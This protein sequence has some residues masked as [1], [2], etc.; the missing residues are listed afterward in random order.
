M[1]SSSEDDEASADEL[2][3]QT[4]LKSAH[5][6]NNVRY[7][8]VALHNAV[9]NFMNGLQRDIGLDGEC[10]E[11]A[12]IIHEVSSWW[13]TERWDRAHPY[14]D[15]DDE[16]NNTS[17]E[18]GDDE[19]GADAKDN[20]DDDEHFVDAEAPPSSP[21]SPTI[22]LGE[23]RDADDGE[24]DDP[25][26]SK[27]G[28][29]S[30]GDFLDKSD[31]VDA[32]RG[33]K[34]QRRVA[35]TMMSNCPSGNNVFLNSRDESSV[36]SGERA[37]LPLNS[38]ASV[39]IV[40]QDDEQGNKTTQAVVRCVVAAVNYDSAVPPP[41][42]AVKS[43]SAAPPPTAAHRASSSET[44]A[45][46]GG[47]A[48]P[49]RTGNA[50]VFTARC[51]PE[52]KGANMALGLDAP[53]NV[54]GT[55]AAFI[56]HG[57]DSSA[58]G[59]ATAAISMNTKAEIMFRRAMRKSTHVANDIDMPVALLLA[60]ALEECVLKSQRPTAPKPPRKNPINVRLVYGDE[61]F[62]S[63]TLKSDDYTVKFGSQLLGASNFMTKDAGSS[64]SNVT[65]EE[66][67]VADIASRR[68]TQSNEEYAKW[69]GTN[70]DA[71][72]VW[73]RK[74]YETEG[75]ALFNATLDT[76]RVL[77]NNVRNGWAPQILFE[78]KSK[79][80]ALLSSMRV[81]EVNSGDTGAAHFDSIFFA[82]KDASDIAKPDVTDEE[83]KRITHTIVTCILAPIVV[84]VRNEYDPSITTTPAYRSIY[85]RFGGDPDTLEKNLK[86]TQPL[87]SLALSSMEQLDG[88]TSTR[89]YGE[90]PYTDLQGPKPTQEAMS[91]L[92]LAKDGTLD[93]SA[94][95][96]H[97]SV[98][99]AAQ[100]LRHMTDGTAQ[101]QKDVDAAWTL[102]MNGRLVTHC[103]RKGNQGDQ[104]W[105]KRIECG[106]GA[107]HE[108]SCSYAV[109]TKIADHH[110]VE[111]V[112]STTTFPTTLLAKW[113]KDD[114]WEKAKAFLAEDRR[115]LFAK[116]KQEVKAL[117]NNGFHG[118]T[119]ATTRRSPSANPTPPR[120]SAT[121]K[122]ATTTDKVGTTAQAAQ[123]AMRTWALA[124]VQHNKAG[125]D[126][127]TSAIGGLLTKKGKALNADA[128]ET[129]TSEIKGMWDEF[130]AASGK[131]P[132]VVMVM[133]RTTRA[134]PTKQ[135]MAAFGR[136]MV[137][138]RNE[139]GSTPKSTTAK[140][141]IKYLVE[142]YGEGG[143]SEPAVNVKKNSG[144]EGEQPLP[145]TKNAGLDNLS[146]AT[147]AEPVHGDEGNARKGPGT[148]AKEVRKKNDEEENK[149]K[150]KENE[151]REAER[152]ANE[153]RNKKQDDAERTPSRKPSSG[154]SV[155]A[156]GSSSQENPMYADAVPV[157]ERL[158][159]KY[160]NN[161]ATDADEKVVEEF[162]E[163]VKG[164]HPGFKDAT[165][166]QRAVLN[167]FVEAINHRY[168]GFTIDD[169]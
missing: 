146:A 129:K 160:E 72:A 88:K 105:A 138:W 98:L 84:L 18:D 67:K 92:L 158:L 28:A 1:S 36:A 164:S 113:Q 32:E 121:K 22:T 33:A 124:S 57:L 49:T 85:A 26:E 104:L 39:A 141:Y 70:S 136:E 97:T 62:L 78:E 52:S 47:N 29:S 149:T 64:E 139:F 167:N 91:K 58:S 43:T 56:L 119:K 53:T 131:P 34:H 12:D 96:P 100:L 159:K 116:L 111:G 66:T 122:R 55:T 27:K 35:P 89:T 8:Q 54:L 42:A 144:N 25:E 155:P 38:V 156:V 120:P 107:G 130:T 118:E 87:R 162:W 133:P 151:S 13:I 48:T 31:Q 3:R 169:N 63:G 50:L 134:V 166:Q 5:T 41:N 61:L 153:A 117:L 142:A 46:G 20:D 73:E 24:A 69:N 51:R 152:L 75:L 4:D 127:L 126:A 2:A 168:F 10:V 74:K 112:A 9:H 115:A 99:I 147:A 145:N 6:P 79:S 94:M 16:D 37:A 14:E 11:L 90:K 137:L 110:A 109:P 165:E 123:S 114:T 82:G 161:D 81:C 15:K 17:N 101:R 83:V 108:D 7:D 93:A 154:A 128:L 150:A 157:I 132:K 102:I 140:T 65:R 30:D 68:Q 163:K 21:R 19:L 106:A 125:F 135:L 77:V 143:F 148:D 95:L 40:R 23:R 44:S 59:W 45:H 80:H 76:C 60:R 103:Q 71:G 86:N